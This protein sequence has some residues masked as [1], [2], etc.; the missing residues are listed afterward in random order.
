MTYSLTILFVDLVIFY[1]QYEDERDV[2]DAISNLRFINDRESVLELGLRQVFLD[3]VYE[4][5]SRQRNDDYGTTVIL[6]T[7]QDPDFVN[8]DSRVSSWLYWKEHVLLLLI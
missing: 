1:L 5:T 3:Y 2:Q 6:I 4:K 8:R 7:D